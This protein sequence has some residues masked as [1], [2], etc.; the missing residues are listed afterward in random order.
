[1]GFY[2]NDCND[3]GIPDDCD[4]AADPSLDCN[5]NLVIDACEWEDCNDNG[6]LDE[7]D[8]L[9]CDGSPWC[10]D[11]NGNGVPD[12]CDIAA[13]ATDC[14][15]N[16]IPDECE[17]DCNGN[18]IVDECDIRDCD[19]SI[20]CDDCNNNGV[21]D[22]CDAGL[23]SGAVYFYDD[24]SA[25][26][27]IGIGA[28]VEIAWIQRF[29]AEPGSETTVA[30]SKCFGN[31]GEF[32]GN[33]GVYPD[34]SF[35][36]F[37]WDDPDGDGAPHDAALLASADAYANE[38]SI[39]IDVL[40]EVPIGP[41]TVSGSF[42]IGACGRIDHVPDADGCGRRACTRIVGQLRVRRRRRIQSER[43]LPRQHRRHRLLVQFPVVESEQRGRRRAGRLQRQRHPRRL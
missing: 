28:D 41:V 6:V 36:V 5:G 39:D 8:I 20:W 19:G 11:C 29:I 17:E 34:Q 32:S 4:I 37:V 30:V 23:P 7:C 2:E 27:S 21:P 42:F 24:G 1:M 15:P 14:Q 40:Q 13:G 26:D 33:S 43:F 31:T 12:V 18:G 9:D 10:S 3:N 35:R 16:G 38:G 22:V 25:E